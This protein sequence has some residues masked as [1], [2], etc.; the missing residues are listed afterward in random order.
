[1]ASEEYQAFQKMMAERP[2][3]PPPASLQELRDRID[4]NAGGLPVADGVTAEPV[5]I[6]G[7][8][9]IVC[10]PDGVTDDA[11]VLVYL[12]GGGFR[13]AS[14]LAYRSFGS[15]IAK[16]MG[17]RVVLVDYR[18]A[19]EDA[20]PAALDD[21]E[22]VYRGLLELGARPEQVAVA[23]DSAGGGLTASLALRTLVEGPVPA[24]L[25]CASPVT[26]LTAASESYDTNA[27]T[28]MLWSKSSAGEVAELY[29]AGHD[30]TDP[31]AS[32]LFG[33][34]D[35]AP[36][37]LIQVSSAETLLDDSRRLAEVAGS[38]GVDVTLHVYDGM[39][40][41]WQM[42]YPAFPEAVEAVDELAAFV[43]RHT[44]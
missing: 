23:G 18:L 17:G 29:L 6:G 19:P 41:V 40:H 36:P 27:S 20:F 13:M 31:E 4:A 42:S 9:C 26:D 16:A 34:W 38:S 39:P 15:H 3:P 24:A 21:T 2:V 37:L 1:M 33:S 5:E 8:S 22:A 14:A 25:I 12:H 30:A 10:R 43:L 44:G 11:P 35:G 7:V 28:D 32:P